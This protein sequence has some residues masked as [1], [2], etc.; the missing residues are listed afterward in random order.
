VVELIIIKKYLHEFHD[1]ALL[2]IERKGQDY[3]LSLESAEMDRLDMKD[4]LSLSERGTIKGKLHLLSVQSIKINES[5]LQDE[6]KMKYD[7]GSIFDFEIQNNL[8]ELQI[9]WRNAPQ[10]PYVNDFSTIVIKAKNIWWENIPDLCD[11]FW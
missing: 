1:G 3:V 6:L 11:P 8:V 10:K 4:G 7:Y 9:S 5:K 2:A